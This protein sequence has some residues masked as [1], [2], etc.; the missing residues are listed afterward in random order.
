LEVQTYPLL[1]ANNEELL[2]RKTSGFEL[3]Y[4]ETP[5][6]ESVKEENLF[7]FIFSYLRTTKLTSGGGKFVVVPKHRG[8]LTLK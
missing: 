8:M 6:R 1:Y 3:Y 5:C 4:F 2:I 7:G